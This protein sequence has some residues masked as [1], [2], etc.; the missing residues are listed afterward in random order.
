MG[1]GLRGLGVQGFPEVNFKLAW[2]SSLLG[3]ARGRG[4]R[5]YRIM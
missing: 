4:L 1:L 5:G 3:N 2:H